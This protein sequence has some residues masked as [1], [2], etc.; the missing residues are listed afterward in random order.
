MQY[1][2][3]GLFNRRRSPDL[4][5]TIRDKKK[6]L[7][8]SVVKLSQKELAIKQSET[9]EHKIQSSGRSAHNGG[10]R[11]VGKLRKRE[12]AAEKKPTKDEWRHETSR[13]GEELKLLTQQN[14]E[15]QVRHIS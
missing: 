7:V 14:T 4:I 2:K 13:M 11:K 6:A 15:L 1:G 10:G 9:V 5:D 8:E 12:R 3:A